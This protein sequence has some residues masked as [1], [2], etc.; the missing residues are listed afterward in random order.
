MNPENTDF[1]IERFPRYCFRPE[2]RPEKESF[3]IVIVFEGL[4]D[5]V[6]THMTCDSRESAYRTCDVFNAQLGLARP[7]WQQMAGDFPDRDSSPPH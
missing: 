4:D 5:C 3:R 7:Q 2:C 1:D 6:M